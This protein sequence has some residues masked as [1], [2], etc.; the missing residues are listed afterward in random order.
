MFSGH[1]VC[2]CIQAL[3]AGRPPQRLGGVGQKSSLHS[4]SLLFKQTFQLNKPVRW[5]SWRLCGHF[6]RKSFNATCFPRLFQLFSV[7]PR[8]F[9]PGVKNPCWYEEYTGNITSDPYQTNLYAHYSRRFRSM[10]QRLRNTFREHLILRDGK[11][12]RMRCLPYFYIIGQPKCGT[13]DLY[14]RL[15]LR[16]DVKFTTFKEPHW[17][18]RKRFGEF[19]KAADKHWRLIKGWN[20]GLSVTEASLNGI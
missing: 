6:F 19:K 5:L 2:A 16:P 9:L 14:D 4:K 12:Y 20:T 7:V 15:R 8:K 11:L 17:W 1:P 13:T 18:T 10:F 3:T